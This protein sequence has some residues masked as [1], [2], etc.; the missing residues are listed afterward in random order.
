MPTQLVFHVLN[1]LGTFAGFVYNH[2]TPDI[3]VVNSH[4]P[5]G[6]VANSLTMLWSI[7]TLISACTERVGDRKVSD[8]GYRHPE[9]TV[10][11]ESPLQNYQ[12]SPHDYRFSDDSGNFSGDSLASSMQSVD[13]R[14]GGRSR[15]TIAQ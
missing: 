12:D 4:H 6:W 1:G 5:V 2:S 13:S 3:Y 9:E 14:Q 15:H 8:Q 10:A 7:F 11:Q